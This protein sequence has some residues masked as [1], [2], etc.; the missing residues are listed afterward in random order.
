MKVLVLLFLATA[1]SFQL[2]SFVR[3][4]TTTTR[5]W[6]AMDDRDWRA[7]RAKLVLQE[8]EP[9]D[10]TSL[11]QDSHWVHAQSI[12]ET[13][14]VLIHTP[15]PQDIYGLGRQCLYES[16]ILVVETNHEETTG[17][18]LNLPTNVKTDEKD[19][20]VHYGGDYHAIQS[21]KPHFYVL[22]Q[23]DSDLP[24]LPGLSMTTMEEATTEDFVYCGHVSWPTEQLACELERGIWTCLSVDTDTLML[25]E[26]TSLLNQAGIFP[27]ASSCEFD[28]HMFQEWSRYHLS[29]DH[30]DDDCTVDSEPK[31]IQSGDLL[32]SS[33]ADHA[34]LFSDQELHKSLL[35]VIQEDDD[36]TVAVV[37]NHASTETEPLTGLPIRYGGNFRYLED[38]SALPPFCLHYLG[39]VVGGEAVGEYFYKACVEQASTAI[40]QGL[41]SED[42]F[43][44]V[45]GMSVFP[46]D[47]VS[48]CA[49][50]DLVSSEIV[51]QV[52]QALST[53][54]PLSPLAMETN[55][56]IARHA[57]NV[58]SEEEDST[59]IH[60]LDLGMDA[61]KTWLAAYL[62]ED[63]DYRP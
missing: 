22:Q 37:L 25:S 57:W 24:I 39:G 16:V 27:A 41:A 8:Q 28:K 7:F 11:G 18:I 19:L 58:A 60:L 56:D 12:L 9:V 44:V 53:Q 6:D 36:F 21:Q 13:G 54:E 52:W 47:E 38:D 34:F 17:L 5:L 51:P 43:L 15:R 59:N 35:L 49:C 63:S 30:D 29:M 20:A 45:Q 62:L 1:Q 10:G 14:S 50:F 32:R 42:D 4:H 55:V 40:E 48:L 61:T 3:R 2:P 31:R 46:K 33:A 23:Q 26:R